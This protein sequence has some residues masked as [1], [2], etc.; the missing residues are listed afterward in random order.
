M[1][2]APFSTLAVAP[3]AS[4]YTWRG[5]AMRSSAWTSTRS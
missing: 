4:L 2:V 1:P 5:A 3:G